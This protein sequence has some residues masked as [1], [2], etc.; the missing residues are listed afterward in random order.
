MPSKTNNISAII[1]TYQQRQLVER[2][3]NALLNDSNSIEIIVVDNGSSDDTIPVLKS[4][5]GTKV[6]LIALGHNTGLA[7]AWNVGAARAKEEILLF[8]DNDTEVQP[9]T[10]AAII[11]YFSQEKTIGAAQCKLLFKAD[12]RRIDCIGEYISPLGLLVQR[13]TVGTLDHPK[14][15][16]AV[17][18]FAA[19]SAAM[20]VRTKAFRQAGG[21]DPIYFQYVLETDL[22]W[23]IW[24]AGY[25]ISFCPNTAVHH[26]WSGS[27]RLFNSSEQRRKIGFQ[28]ARNTLLTLFKNLGRPRLLYMVPINTGLWVGLAG[29]KFL[30]G[31]LDTAM[32]IVTGL[33]W[34][35][36]HPRVIGR[37]RRQ[38]QQ[39]RKVADT[40][41]LPRL[42]RK[43]SLSY[44]IQKVIHPYQIKTS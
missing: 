42:T 37:R 19:K 39:Q 9:G 26:V 31:D 30:T 32:G 18:L 10:L 36:S 7:H 13:A 43:K 5:F 6:T 38:V 27:S 40:T 14:Y 11:K 2:C 4:R 20:A 33:A 22:C 29:W 28:S 15:N 17:E 16:T 8:L 35:A 25:R 34:L 23:R 24:L 44:F 21:F 3:I 1:T 12:P 41:F